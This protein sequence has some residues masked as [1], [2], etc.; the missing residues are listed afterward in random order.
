M[1]GATAVLKETLKFVET[2]LNTI[3]QISLED[4]AYNKLYLE[5]REMRQAT[6][7]VLR[8]Q[9]AI[10][11]KEEEQEFFKQLSAERQSEAKGSLADIKEH[12]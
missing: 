6:M 1:N 9:Y 7:R 12:L 5:L 2:R 8:A 4:D 3:E 10:D 11:K